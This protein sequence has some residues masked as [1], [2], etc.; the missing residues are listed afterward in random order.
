MVAL[1]DE[2][3]SRLLKLHELYKQTEA[4]F[5]EVDKIKEVTQRRVNDL[6][7]HQADLIWNSF[8]KLIEPINR[9]CNDLMCKSTE[10]KKELFLE[11]PA[12]KI[13]NGIELRKHVDEFSFEDFGDIT[14]KYKICL[15]STKEVVGYIKYRG[16]HVNSKMAD[17]GYAVDSKHRGHGYAYE[18]LCLL[19]ELLK[20]NGIEDFWISV[21]P[22]NLPSV[23]TIEKYGASFLKSMD[24]VKVFSCK[25]FMLGEIKRD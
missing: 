11:L 20:E 22:D 24:D 3:K 2:Q 4:L 25:T 5:E 18:A 8:Y 1:T 9:R 13:G 7:P 14:G 19:S 15:S 10:L 17:V 16:Y 23:R 12:F 6:D 21:R